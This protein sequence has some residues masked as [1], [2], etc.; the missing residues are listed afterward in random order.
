MVAAIENET[1]RYDVNT[2]RHERSRAFV[3]GNGLPA[4]LLKRTLRQVGATVEVG[5]CATPLRTAA[6]ATATAWLGAM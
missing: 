3:A 1:G 4:R 6:S 5:R 2:R